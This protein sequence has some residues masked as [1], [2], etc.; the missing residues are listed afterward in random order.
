MKKIA[1]LGSRDISVKI[2]KWIIEQNDCEIVGVVTPTYKTW[3]NDKLKE[4]AIRWGINTFDDI[5][6][7]I[8]LKPDVIFSINY[9]KLITEEHINAM[10]GN[11]INLNSAFNEFP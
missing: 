7:V 9:W 5:Q 10:D 11:I 4:T 3:W 2:L 1:I 6:D 8:D